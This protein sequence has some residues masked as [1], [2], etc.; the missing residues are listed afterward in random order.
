MWIFG[1]W[2]FFF[3]LF[4]WLISLQD[5]YESRDDFY[6]FDFA[7]SEWTRINEAGVKTPKVRSHNA[8]V[9]GNAMYIVGGYGG[10]THPT[11]MFKYDFGKDHFNFVCV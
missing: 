9:Y 4:V 2:V 5:G 7:T 11:E 8:I 1:G 6:C 3:S 10:E